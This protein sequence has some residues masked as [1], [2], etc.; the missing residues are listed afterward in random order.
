M[1]RS[2]LIW[3]GFLALI[4]AVTFVYWP[5]LDG[6]FILDDL[7]NIANNPAIHLESLTLE[8]LATAYYAYPGWPIGR[9]LATLSLAFNYWHQGLDPF[10]YKLTN[11]ILHL[12]NGA[13]ILMLASRLLSLGWRSPDSN[14]SPWPPWV[15]LALAAVWLFHPLQVST[16][17][18][19][20]QRMEIMA[21]SFTLA[22]LLSYSKGRLIQMEKTE[23]GWGWLTGSLILALVGF[24][25]KQ[26]AVLFP[27]YILVLELA[28]FGFS[29][30]SHLS[31]RVLKLLF[32]FGFLFAA[33][34]FFFLILPPYLSAEAYAYRDFSLTERLLTQLRVLPFYLS[35][36]LVPIPDRMLFFYDSYSASQSLLLPWTTLVGGLFLF[37]L[38]VLTLLFRK[39]APV[40]TLGM[41]WFFVSHALTS[42]IF[43][44]ELVFEHR[45]YF[46]LFGVIMAVAALL[47]LIP[48]RSGSAFAP[49]IVVVL[50]T[51]LATIT[52]TRTWT[53]GD[54]LNLALHHAHINPSSER[55][56]TELGVIY[57]NMASNDPHSVMYRSTV[58]RLE[59]AARQHKASPLP[60][61]ALIVFA[62]HNGQDAEEQWWLSLIDKFKK[63]PLGAQERAA[64]TRLIENRMKG[65]PVSDHWLE[66][67]FDALTNRSN[68]PP[69]MLA[70]FGFYGLETLRD[71][72]L[73]RMA[74]I[75]ARDQRP[76]DDA[77]HQKLYEVLRDHGHDDLA[78]IFL[79]HRHDTNQD[80]PGTLD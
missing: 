53:W 43:A 19:A 77:L 55:A 5:G 69:E 20:V 72:S 23:G 51:G 78:R 48:S 46:G 27:A 47:R 80:K 49:I 36:I 13:L 45:N 3:G 64:L 28:L 66:K 25:S 59:R 44:L 62:A 15:P 56:H 61:Q 52:A 32:S 73:A 21:V 58:L 7:P 50:I 79:T 39:T 75:A 57:G 24:L 63:R 60:E 74:F 18:Y 29:A 41:L 30:R 1:T 26:T 9:P 38:L 68:V 22:A 14:I 37:A 2:F 67:V 33:F 6:P 40:F 8:N 34:L 76:E 10:G 35:L 11:L 16:V 70:R 31:Q 42:N 65:L 17:L 4:L 54:R 12:L 71:E